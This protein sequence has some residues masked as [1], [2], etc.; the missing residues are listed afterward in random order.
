MRGKGYA[1]ESVCRVLRSMGCPIAA[2][3][4][5]AWK[6]SK[7][8][9]DRDRSDAALIDAL[10]AVRGSPE[11]LYGRRK[12]TAHLRRTGFDVAYCTVHRLMGDL[13]MSGVRRGR[14][15]RTTIPA[16]DAVRAGDLLNRDFTAD[17]PD[18]RWIADFT[19]VPTPEGFVYVA[20]V[21]DC[22]A[23]RIVGW[24]AATRRPVDLVL[25]PVKAALA[26]RGRQGRPAAK[27]LVHH[28]DAGSQYTS[29]AFTEHLALEQMA[30]SVGSIG[31]AYD[32][33]LM[34]SVIGL[35]KA[36]AVANPSLFRAGP[37]RGLPDVEKLTAAWAWWWNNKRLH[38]TLANRTP[39]E[40]ETAYH[41]THDP[42]GP[43]KTGP[44]MNP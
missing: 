3:T 28:S 41:E 15:V 1:V 8:P 23:Q 29:I 43:T 42:T 30:P 9:S 44:A 12:M 24:N 18:T 20:F 4:Y 21:V 36:E 11:S 5:R 31:D 17:A 33:A 35:Y 40:T 32:N 7:G 2:R 39:A 37:L 22:F 14:P 27:G 19:Y 25:A 13:G 6:A 16:K 38:S 26:E 34:E 10:L